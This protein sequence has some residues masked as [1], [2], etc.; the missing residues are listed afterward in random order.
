MTLYF[1]LSLSLFL[2]CWQGGIQK[3][4][5][6]SN[7]DDH[8]S[9][10]CCLCGS[11]HGHLV[12][13]C[14]HVCCLSGH[15]GGLVCCLNDHYHHDIHLP[16]CLCRRLCCR[17]PGYRCCQIH[18]VLM[19]DIWSIHLFWKSCWRHNYTNRFSTAHLVG[20]AATSYPSQVQSPSLGSLL[21]MPPPPLP[22]PCWSR[23]PPLPPPPPPRRS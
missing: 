7:K 15:H 23:K 17:R 21:P 13:C 12:H 18:Q 6:S 19:R 22:P 2:V 5:R 1:C 3:G 10:V 20:P 11:R 16:R 14:N 8:V 9:H 4:N